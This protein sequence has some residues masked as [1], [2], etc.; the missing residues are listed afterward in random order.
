MHKKKRSTSLTIIGFLA[1]TLFFS[2]LQP[3]LATGLTDVDKSH[4]AYGDIHSL[5]EKNV[6]NGYSN[7]TFKPD[8]YVTRAQAAKIISLAA[9][10]KP[11]KPEKASYP[12]VAPD[13]WAFGYIEA[14][15]K[16]GVIHGKVFRVKL[17]QAD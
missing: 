8:E 17:L 10:I 3:G 4:W 2:N 7:G 1:I 11:V 15:K 6:L 14:L 12:D 13:Y 5:M 9:D 16:A